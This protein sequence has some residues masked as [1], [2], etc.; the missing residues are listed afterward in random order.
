MV[1]IYDGADENARKIGPFCGTDRPADFTSSG[2]KLYVKLTTDGS[3]TEK[4][5]EARFRANVPPPCESILTGESGEFKS[6]NFP[7]NYPDN[8]ECTW[9]ITVPAGKKLIWNSIPL[10]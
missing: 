4:G 3:G 6:P 2:N 8:A 9:E 7:E 5:F 1:E 10:M